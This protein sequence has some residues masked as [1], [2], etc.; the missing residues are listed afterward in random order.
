VS[1]TDSLLLQLLSSSCWLFQGLAVLHRAS[2]P[3]SQGTLPEVPS[4]VLTPVLGRK[5]DGSKSFH[6][7]LPVIT[8]QISYIYC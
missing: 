7:S 4:P 2:L 6:V 8:Y 3:P 1:T 5:K